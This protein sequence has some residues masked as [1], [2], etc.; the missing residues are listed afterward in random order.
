[1]KYVIKIVMD[2]LAHREG[3]ICSRWFNANLE[4]AGILSCKGLSVK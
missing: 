2:G 4:E 3:C 1:M